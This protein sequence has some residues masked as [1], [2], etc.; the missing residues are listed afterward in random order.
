V[1]YLDTVFDSSTR[2]LNEVIKQ[3]SQR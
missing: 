2:I 1:V 3:L